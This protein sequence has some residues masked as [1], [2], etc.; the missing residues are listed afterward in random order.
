MD[1]EA[2]VTLLMV[3]APNAKIH[4]SAVCPRIKDQV[5]HKVETL[6]EA[7]KELATRLDVAIS[8]AGPLMTYRNGAVDKS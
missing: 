7:F 8:D 2:I 5:Q 4:I 1:M 3:K 6:I